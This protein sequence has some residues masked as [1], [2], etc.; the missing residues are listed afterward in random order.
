[1]RRFRPVPVGPGRNRCTSAKAQQT[2]EADGV[3]YERRRV[4]ERGAGPKQGKTTLRAATRC[5]HACIQLFTVELASRRALADGLLHFSAFSLGCW[6]LRQS[7]WRPDGPNEGH[8]P[9]TWRPPYHVRFSHQARFFILPSSHCGCPRALAA[10]RCSGP[11]SVCRRS[12]SAAIR[13]FRARF[14]RPRGSPSAQPRA[15]SRFD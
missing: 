15:Q 2:D 1:M 3:H 5:Q 13:P 10:W 12:N 7:R 6:R 11:T 9:P 4:N 8:W 14:R